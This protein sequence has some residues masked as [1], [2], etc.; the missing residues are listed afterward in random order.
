MLFRP[1]SE[2]F[3]STLLTTP[4]WMLDSLAIH[5][6]ASSGLFRF[7]SYFSGCCFPLFYIIP[8]LT[9]KYRNSSRLKPSLFS[10]LILCFPTLDSFLHVHMSVH[11]SQFTSSPGS[12]P[13]CPV[14]CWQFPLGNVRVTSDPTWPR[15]QNCTHDLLF[16]C[17]ALKVMRF[18]HCVDAI[19]PRIWVRQMKFLLS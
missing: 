9:I 8:S 16:I 13:L 5:H 17:S 6:I 19:L 3:A 1:L 12:W 11:E 14:S 15:F 7:S 2:Q 18:S 10:V 4:P